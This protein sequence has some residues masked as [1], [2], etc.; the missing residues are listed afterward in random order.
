MQMT[1]IW[2]CLLQ[3]AGSGPWPAQSQPRR[4]KQAGNTSTFQMDSMPLSH[5]LLSKLIKSGQTFL[6]DSKKILC[7]FFPKT[8]NIQ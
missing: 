8:V 4:P 6:P 2:V 3:A 1:F 5:L 7:P